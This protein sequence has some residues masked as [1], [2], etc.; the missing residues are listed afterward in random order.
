MNI[1]ASMRAVKVASIGLILLGVVKVAAA[2]SVKAGCISASDMTEIAAHFVQ[3]ESLAGKEYCYDDSETS[4]LLESFMFMRS[5]VFETSMPKSVDELFS[6][7]FAND[8][9]GYFIGRVG[10]IRIDT[11]CPKG[12]VAYVYAFGG[13]TMFVCSTALTKLFTSMDRASV[14]MH[15]ARHLDGF[16]HVTCKQGPRAGLQGACDR[17]ISAGG[18]YAVTVETYAQLAKYATDL[19]PALRAYARSTAVVYAHET[20]EIPATV[21]RQSQFLLMSEQG[22]FYQMD[23]TGAGTLTQLGRTPALGHIVMR[24]NHMILIPEDRNEDSRFVFAQN[25]GE[26]DQQ[27]HDY[28]KEYNEKSPTERAELVDWHISVL[29]GAKVYRNRVILAC[30]PKSTKTQEL[31]LP[32]SPV[33]LLYPNGVDRAAQ[34]VHLITESGSVLE[35]GCDQARTAF[36][37]ASALVLDQPFKRL[38]RSGDQVVGLTG[39][40]QLFRLENGVSTPISTD[41]D[42]QVFELAPL[43]T[44]TFFDL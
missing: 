18:S 3:Y 11:G 17:Q 21:D 35:V 5:T 20:F 27:P 25:Q 38:Y 12:V 36:V 19:H 32:S 6:G 33:S 31:S 9:W 26:I 13:D 42:G 24:A 43:Q 28:A 14:F 29:W 16:P 7:K 8:W 30:D 34:E 15:E 40:Q 22:D 23:V 10:N 2:E 1:A 44:F 39:A 41:L 4:A 37:R